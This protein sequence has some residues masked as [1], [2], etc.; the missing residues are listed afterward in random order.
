MDGGF[1]SEGKLHMIRVI[2]SMGMSTM[3]TQIH[4]ILELYVC[5]VCAVPTT[6]C[7]GRKKSVSQ[8]LRRIWFIK[9]LMVVGCDWL[10]CGEYSGRKGR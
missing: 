3:R 1:S 4:E 7:R 2:I 5:R 6:V 10:R 9:R 8:L